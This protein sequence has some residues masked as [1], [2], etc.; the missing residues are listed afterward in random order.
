MVKI[1]EVGGCVRDTLLGLESKDV[2]FVVVAPS[3]EAME[4]H[5]VHELG[6]SVYMSKPEFATI[7]AGVPLGHELRKRCKDAD[8]VLARRDGPSSDGRRPDYV[9]PGQLE[10]DLARRDFT[11]NA[12]ARD[13]Y[14]GE[15]IDLHG[16]A[17]DLKDKI[18]RFVGDPMTRI[19]EDG[20]RVLRALRFNVT[21]G[22]D[23]ERETDLA[24]HS[25]RAAEMLAA[26]S[27]ERM[28]EELEKM[29][30]LSTLYTLDLL[31]DFPLIRSAVFRPETGLRLSATFKK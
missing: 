25:Q 18:L 9:E 6:L 13:P 27:A 4:E 11:V 17:R 23:F 2:D 3:F 15:L 19:C 22:F 14:T 7:R 31:E 10:D 1:Y 20:L 8:F 16:G 26:V 24:L 12:L 21:K 30:Q 29:F 5:I 28:R